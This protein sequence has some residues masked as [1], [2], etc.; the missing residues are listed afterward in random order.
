M[1]RVKN[2]SNCPCDQQYIHAQ[3]KRLL[4]KSVS[5]RSTHAIANTDHAS[6]LGASVAQSHP[7]KKKTLKFF[8]RDQIIEIVHAEKPALGPW[9][10]PLQI[11]D[12]PWT[13]WSRGLVDLLL[14]PKIYEDEIS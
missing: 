10:I 12:A 3:Y 7:H 1:V 13:A 8:W 4:R 2:A 11:L 6:S 14:G 9:P 5:I